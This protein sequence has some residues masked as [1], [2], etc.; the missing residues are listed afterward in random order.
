[1]GLCI[2][3]RVADPDPGIQSDLDRVYFKKL[4]I[5]N[6][7]DNIDRDTKKMGLNDNITFLQ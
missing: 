6:L 2:L 5:E 1:M 7:P 4:A 3:A